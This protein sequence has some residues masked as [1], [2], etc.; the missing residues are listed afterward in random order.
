METS[1]NE[2]LLE[3]IRMVES[4]VSVTFPVNGRSMLPFIIGGKESLILAKPEKIKVGDIIL[5]FVDGKRF[6]IHRVSC[7]QGENIT[8]MG[9]GNLGSKEYCKIGDV[10]ALATHAVNPAGIRRDLYTKRRR[11]AAKLWKW[12][13]P[14]RKYL[15]FIYRKTHPG[16]L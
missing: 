12:A 15:L 6:V 2:I 14:V 7:I 3:A 9:D 8:L 10:K 5:A 13:I 1:G 16:N 4:G 11:I